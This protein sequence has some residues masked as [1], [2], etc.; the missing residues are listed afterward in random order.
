MELLD[1]TPM[2]RQEETEGLEV[3]DV[4]SVVVYTDIEVSA[5]DRHRVG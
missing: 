4:A 2:A 5:G 3:V 1:G